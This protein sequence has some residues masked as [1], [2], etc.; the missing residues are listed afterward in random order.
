MKFKFAYLYILLF[1]LFLFSCKTNKLNSDLQNT[2]SQLKDSSIA[3]NPIKKI[4]ENDPNLI[5]L[6]DTVLRRNASYQIEYQQIQ[7][8]KQQFGMAASYLK[9]FSSLVLNPSQRKF[10]KYTMDGIGNY[11]TKFSPNITPEMRIPEYLPDFQ[12]GLQTNWEIDVWGKL[13]DR[14]KAQALRYLSSQEGYKWLK[15]QL[16][17]KTAIAYG[18]LV[19]L[20]RELTILYSN[21]EIQR[22]AVELVKI[23]KEAGVVNEMAVLQ[24]EAQLENSRSQVSSLKSEIVQI[25]NDIR[26]LVND[27][28]FKITR[29]LIPIDTDFSKSY[30]EIPLDY[31]SQRPDVR[32]A[33]LQLEAQVYDNAAAKLALKPSLVLANFTGVQGF[34]PEYLFQLPASLSY[35]ILG[36]L[37]APLFNRNLIKAEINI[38]ESRLKSLEQS[39]LLTLNTAILEWDSN[40]KGL[41]FMNEQIQHKAK[42]VA[43][44]IQSIQTV[45][46]LFQTNKSNYLEVL[47][48][49]QNAL[50]SELDLLEIYKK[51]WIYSVQLY[52]ILGGN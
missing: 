12:I 23:Q 17:A 25:E 36:N 48:A 1:S 2:I 45:G 33:Q 15:T 29:T 18:E 41:E 40:I 49:Q 37:S 5:A 38:S 39:Y 30:R 13:Q 42:E 26:Q 9:P 34:R 50:K 28:S 19:A 47:T 44:N 7:I 6:I 24:L 14:K 32:Q 51:R 43:L 4:W 8:A 46:E 22:K 52:K 3:I 31:L 11:D 20:D 35:S 27:K 10:G 21:I 16:I